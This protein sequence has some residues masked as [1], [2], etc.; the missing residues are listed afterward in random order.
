[1]QRRKNAPK[2]PRHQ[3]TSFS[4]Q[5]RCRRG[6]VSRDCNAAYTPARQHGRT[7]RKKNSVGSHAGSHTNA[8]GKDPQ[9]QGGPQR[10]APEY[11]QY[12]GIS[13]W[14]ALNHDVGY[15]RELEHVTGYIRTLY[16]E[17][18]W[19][20]FRVL[21]RPQSLQRLRSI[22]SSK[23]KFL[24]IRVPGNPRSKAPR[25]LIVMLSMLEDVVKN[26]ASSSVPPFLRVVDPRAV[27]GDL[28]VSRP[29]WHQTKRCI[30]HWWVDVSTIDSI[31][32]S[33]L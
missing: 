33:G 24:P 22:R 9:E 29:P 5:Q 8:H 25:M 18:T 7:L 12:E 10:D 4:S 21:N 15:P 3:R 2:I 11:E 19:K 23:E 1:M 32:N 28:A 6:D 27:L 30:L 13:N 20:K 26:A 16:T 14:L 17:C 31:E